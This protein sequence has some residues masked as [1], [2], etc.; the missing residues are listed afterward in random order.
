MMVLRLGSKEVNCVMK[1]SLHNVYFAHIESYVL[2][3]LYD[4]CGYIV[5]SQ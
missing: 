5:L 2:Q 1:L 4:K 3:T